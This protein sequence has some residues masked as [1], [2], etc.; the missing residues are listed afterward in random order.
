MT[1]EGKKDTEA[2]IL[3][4]GAKYPYAYDKGEKWNT[5]LKVAF[6]PTAVLTDPRGNVIWSGF[7]GD[8]PENILETLIKGALSSPL[9]GWPKA[10]APIKKAFLDRQLGKA[11]SAAQAFAKTDTTDGPGL[12]KAVEQ[13]IQDWVGILNSR[14]EKGDFMRASDLGNELKKEL[15]G[16]P[17]L[18]GIE[19]IL[20][21]IAADKQAQKVI[22]GQKEV[23][24]LRQEEVASAKKGEEIIEQLEKISKNYSGTAAA[25]DAMEYKKIL[26]KQLKE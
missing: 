16:Q 26:E 6:L 12:L 24:K 4:H 21:N 20:K 9:Y 14:V 18:P 10:A 2:W 23:L 19:T 5:A 1:G 3:Q 22:K 8:M 17:E 25:R 15:A 13:Y 7:P 11:R